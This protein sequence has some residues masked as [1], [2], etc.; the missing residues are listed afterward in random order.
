MASAAEYTVSLAYTN[1]SSVIGNTF[2]SGQLITGAEASGNNQAGDREL[3]P[4]PVK[5]GLVIRKG[6]SG[7]TITSNTISGYYKR[8]IYIAGAETDPAAT[9]AASVSS[10]KITDLLLSGIEVKK[11]SAASIKNNQITGSYNSKMQDSSSKAQ[12]PSDYRF[13]GIL[14]RAANVSL[15]DNII[16]SCLVPIGTDTGTT[17]KIYYNTYASNKVN[18]IEVAASYD[19]DGIPAYDP[20]L[21][22]NYYSAPSRVA[23]V[24]AAAANDGTINLT[25]P[26]SKGTFG[27]QIYRAASRYGS[28]KRLTTLTEGISSPASVTYAD[29]SAA[30]GTSAAASPAAYYYKIRCYSVI[31]GHKAI[32]LFA[33]CSAIVFSSPKER[34]Q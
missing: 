14:L 15:A 10:N 23:K 1:A 28:Y 26:P 20:G 33:K 29:T 34:N 19:D 30:T 17:A 31:P 16:K 6:S 4:Q 27:Y 18:Q 21:S 22:A 7:I 9:S 2:T 8:G 13:R 25:W 11:A 3:S 24:S 12:Y 5:A 32:K